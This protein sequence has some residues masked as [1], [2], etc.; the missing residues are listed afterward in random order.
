MSANQFPVR[1]CS[2][3]MKFSQLLVPSHSSSVWEYNYTQ[4]AYSSFCLPAAYSVKGI[5]HE[6]EEMKSLCLYPSIC[7]S[8]WMSVCLPLR[9]SW[10][11]QQVTWQA[12]DHHPITKKKLEMSSSVVYICLCVLL[13][14]LYSF[15][16]FISFTYKK[17]IFLKILIW[18]EKCTHS[19]M[20]VLNR[21][22]KFYFLNYQHYKLLIVRASAPTFIWQKE[23]YIREKQ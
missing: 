4:N 2:F 7:Q 3:L 13:S 12:G 5:S 8:A 9:L 11:R 18:F 15:G 20:Q 19:Y 23:I 1:T 10:I 6:A 16:I 14:L 22:N 17:N 21:L